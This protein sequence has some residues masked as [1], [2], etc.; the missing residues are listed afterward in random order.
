MTPQLSGA[1]VGALGGLGLVLVLRRLL[2]MRRVDLG[3]RV[4]PY[5]RDLQRSAAPGQATAPTAARAVFGPALARAGERLESVLG[6]SASIRR[7]LQ[8][9]G[10]PGTV[11]EFRTEQVLWGC[12]GLAAAAAWGAAD[13]GSGVRGIPMF[14][15]VCVL[16]FATGVVL[17]DQRLAARVKDRERRI[18]LEFPA[19]AELL[20]LAVAAGESPVQALDRVVRR[21]NG[22]LAEDLGRVLAEIRTG[23]PV[24][25]AFD[26]YAASSGLPLVARFAEGIAVAVERGTPLADVLHAQAADVREAGRRE[27]IEAGAQREVLMMLPVVF[28]VL[29]TVVVFAF[30][31]GVVGLSLVTP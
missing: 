17:R 22:A 9:A 5:L 4:L 28:L 25:R 6:G 23:A 24:G 27:L 15:V 20:A 2:A 1:L 16:G 19:I 3:L 7:R 14:A 31:P 10:G 30:F 12:A 21:S 29:P 26:A 8:R 18:L 13:L 11:A